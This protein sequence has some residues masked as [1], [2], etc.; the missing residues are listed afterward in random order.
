MSNNSYEKLVIRL[1]EKYKSNDV[2]PVEYILKEHEAIY[3]TD[4][5]YKK[6][7]ISN[8]KKQNVLSVLDKRRV[9]L[10]HSKPF[11]IKH[12]EETKEIYDK[13]KKQ[14][15]LINMLVW[16]TGFLSDFM[17][18][19][20]FSNMIIVEVEDIA[21][22]VI[23]ALLIEEYDQLYSVITDKMLASDKI[24]YFTKKR[25]VLKK[26]KSEYPK[27][28]KE[29]RSIPKLEK[30]LVDLYVDKIFLAYQ[31]HELNYIYENA[32]EY[33]D[34]DLTTLYRYAKI[35][36]KKNEIQEFIKK[37]QVPERYKTYDK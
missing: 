35:R 18:H 22:E 36:N 26:L 16:D 13:I 25:V 17:V 37:L 5:K 23:W 20:I 32:F 14:Y 29:D 6:R 34:I 3:G 7:I 4:V 30:I 12:T 31:G 19:Q 24:P 15:P 27:V 21:A 9:I 33:W 8:L 10:K 11:I 1:N 28:E 2:I